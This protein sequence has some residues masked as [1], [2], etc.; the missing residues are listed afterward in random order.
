[1]PK[2]STLKIDKDCVAKKQ[3][4]RDYLQ[5]ILAVC[6][7]FKVRVD[8]IRMCPSAR[9]GQHFCVDITPPVSA[10]LANRI[11]YLLGDDCQR[12]AFNQARIES[13]LAEWNKLFARSNV[14]LRTIYRSVKV[15]AG[16]K[17]GRNGR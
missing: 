9:K 2:T 17:V 14:R 7:R 16:T 10:K 1:M 13:G 11:Q 12:V 3:W 5:L 4:I 15:P 8:T 6:K